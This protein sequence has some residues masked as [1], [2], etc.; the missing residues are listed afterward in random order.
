MTMMIESMKR[1]LKK[2]TLTRE[3]IESL[4]GKAITQEEFEYIIAE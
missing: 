4:V 1:C 3:K 2:G